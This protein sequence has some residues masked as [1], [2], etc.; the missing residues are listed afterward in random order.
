MGRRLGL[1]VGINNYL[2]PTFR[3]LQYAETDAKA[4]AQWLVDARG[5]GWNPADVHLSLGM[6]ATKERLQ[7]QLIQL[8]AHAAE[9]GDLVFVYFAGHAF[10]DEAIGEGFLAGSNT[11]YRQPGSAIH[12]LSLMRQVLVPSRASQVVIMLDCFQT[13]T[14]WN[15]LRSTPFDF[16]PLIGPALQQALQQCQGRIF[17][18]ACRGNDMASEAGEKGMGVVLY[19]TIVGLSG[20]AKHPSTGHATLQQ[21]YA[22]VA[23]KPGAQLHPQIFGQELR[24]IVLVGDMPAFVP[25]ASAVP[26]FSA[27]RAS[28]TS[29]GQITFQGVGESGPLVDLSSQSAGAAATGQL[30]PSNSTSGQLSLTLMEQNRQQQCMKLLQQASQLLQAQNILEALGLIEQV[31]QINPTFIDALTLKGHILGSTGNFPEAL[32]TVEQLIQIEPNNALAWNMQAVLLTNMGRF[33]EALVAIER[34]IALDPQNPEAGAIRRTIQ[35]NLTHNLDKWQPAQST[36]EPTPVR[37]SR[38]RSFLLSA[39][40]QIFALVIG[41]AGAATLVLQPHLPVIAFLMESFGLALLCVLAARGAFLYGMG[42]LLFTILLCLVAAG[43]L[44]GIYKFEYTRLVNK[45]VAN[46]ALMV[47][48]LFLAFWLIVATIMPLLLGIG[49]FIAGAAF[50]VRK[51][52][53]RTSFSR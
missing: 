3:P 21:L 35:A 18:C 10:I 22:H 13:G 16:R 20:P 42:R 43:A 38:A 31:L 30:S 40:L 24:P 26:S 47:P 7:A 5:A 53:W 9:A 1:F 2:D 32:V 28:A 25:A 52:S 11:I 27:A 48:V 46:P 12:L 6:E 36:Y 34:S 29:T 33:R 50:G 49:G 41:S 45:I 39:A 37:R 14:A 23:S 44:G 15:T 4:F 51:K 8:C 17:Y 19:R